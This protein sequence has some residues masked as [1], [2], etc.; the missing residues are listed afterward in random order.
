M[1]KIRPSPLSVRKIEKAGQLPEILERM[2]NLG[3]PIEIFLNI[4]KLLPTQQLLVCKAV[5][6]TWN[7]IISR[8]FRFENLVIST[9]SHFNR[10]WY[11]S[12]EFACPDDL[13][14]ISDFNRPVLEQ[15]NFIGLKR[16]FLYSDKEYPK[17]FLCSGKRKR[18]SLFPEFSVGNL[19]NHLRQL[20]QLEMF[21]LRNRAKKDSIVLKSLKTLHIGQCYWNHL[22]IDC[23]N[24]INLKLQ[25]YERLPG[26]Y[27]FDRQISFK[28]PESVRSLEIIRM[29]SEWVEQF[30]N[31]EKLSLVWIYGARNSF[32]Y[33]NYG[34]STA[35]LAINS[36]SSC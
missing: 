13:I 5:N 11:L 36:R 32:L 22:W 25:N 12:N 7:W 6:K 14:K 10:R 3:V 31:L 35:G 20:E 29:R 28:Y 15:P 4:I 1:T 24:L 34:C 9:T 19:V 26:H 16:L 17:A 30:G 21:D 23:P 33:G 27:D 18:K 8:E 2:E